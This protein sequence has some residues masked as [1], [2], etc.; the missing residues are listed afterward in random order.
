MN[1]TIKHIPKRYTQPAKSDFEDL[2]LAVRKQ[3]KR[4]YSD[5]QLQRLPEIDQLHA[6]HAE[7]K[8]RKRSADRLISRLWKKRRP[9]KILE[10]GCGNGWLSAKMADVPD[11]QVIGL[12]VNQAEINQALR[13]FK[14]HNLEFVYDTYNENT[15]E[16]NKF[17]V[18]VFAASLQYFP[19]VVNVLNQALSMLDHRGEVYI[20]DT[21]FYDALEVGDADQRS[22]GYYTSMGYPEMAEYYYHHSISEFWG[23]KYKILFNPDSVLNRIFKRDPFYWISIRK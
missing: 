19:S 3:E 1:L 21:H 6:H 9:L 12:D 4:V 5:E 8:I 13:V 15:F 16:N 20:L 22:R 11:S 17:D 23:Y 14:K 7:W 18:I 2:Y 10:V